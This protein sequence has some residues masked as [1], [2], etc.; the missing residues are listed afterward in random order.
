MK[1]A[2]FTLLTIIIIMLLS[3]L[4]YL[5]LS[6]LAYLFWPARDALQAEA[7][8]S[9]VIQAIPVTAM[10]LQSEPVNLYEELPGRTAPYKVSEVRPRVSGIITARLFEEGSEVTEGQQLYQISSASYQAAYNKAKA[11]LAKAKANVKSVQAQKNRYKELIKIDAIS[12]QEYDNVAASLGQAKADVTIAKAAITTAKINLDY[13]KVYAP[14]SGRIS[15]S[16]VTKGALVTANQPQALA[17]ITQ[18]DPIYV[19]LTQPSADLIRMRRTIKGQKI[20]PVTLFFEGEN[21]AYKHKG[22]LRFTGVT[23]DQTTDSVQL[24][25][26][27][28]NPESILLTGMFVHAHIELGTVNAILVPQRAAIR[29]ANGKLSVWIVNKENKVTLKSI[30][31]EKAIGDKW[32]VKEG[33][34]AGDIIVLEGFQRIASGTLVNPTYANNT[35]TSLADSSAAQGG[36]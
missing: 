21:A 15:K 19:D 18:L 29:G 12:N 27:F 2:I 28:P 4:A 9:N 11:G 16:T 17:T 3:A 32:L 10:Q 5:F 23:V 26:L 7:Q 13:T 6:A 34:Q 1:K 8:A 35:T 25:S 31:V 20:T 36:H 24:R 22:I 33:I 14:I 30:S